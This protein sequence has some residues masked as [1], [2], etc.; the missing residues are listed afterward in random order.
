MAMALTAGY[1]VLRCSHVL[2][3]FYLIPLRD[4]YT[5]AVWATALFGQTVEWGGEILTLD[6][7]GRIIRP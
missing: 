6:R 7:A 4:L 5:V 2:K 1:G 3:Y